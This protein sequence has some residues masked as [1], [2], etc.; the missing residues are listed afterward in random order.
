ME[1]IGILMSIALMEIRE[2]FFYSTI[3]LHEFQGAARFSRQ[4]LAFTESR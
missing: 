1:K 2:W 4:K 3:G